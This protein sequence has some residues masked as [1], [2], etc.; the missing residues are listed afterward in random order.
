MTDF[1]EFL[2]DRGHKGFHLNGNMSIILLFYADDL[3]LLADSTINMKLVLSSLK[4]Y[5]AENFLQVNLNK[6]LCTAKRVDRGNILKYFKELQ[7]IAVSC[8]FGQLLN[9][10]LVKRVIC[11]LRDATLQ[12]SF[13]QESDDKLTKAYILEKSSVSES[14][15]KSGTNL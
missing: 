10:L 8:K 9:I 7:K 13:L 14:A 12:K 1:D 5:C 3:V 11:G 4:V 6:S 2:R 15:K